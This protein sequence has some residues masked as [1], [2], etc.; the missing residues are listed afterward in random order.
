M[1]AKFNIIKAIL[2]CLLYMLLTDFSPR[3]EQK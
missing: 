3:N 2:L 1:H